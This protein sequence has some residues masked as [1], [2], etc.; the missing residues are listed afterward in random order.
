MTHASLKHESCSRV[1]GGGGLGACPLRKF[2]FCILILKPLVEFKLVHIQ[3]SFITSMLL[4]FV[5]LF[6]FSLQDGHHGFC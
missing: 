3:V 2:D 5:V 1:G 6:P 4:I